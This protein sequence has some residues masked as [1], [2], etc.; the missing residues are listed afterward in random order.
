MTESQLQRAAR[1]TT[2][3]SGWSQEVRWLARELERA[4][5]EADVRGGEWCA[6]NREEGRGPCGACAWCCQQAN[7]MVASLK[8]QVTTVERS[9]VLEQRRTIDAERAQKAAQAHARSA[10]AA[11]SDLKRSLDV[12]REAER[13]VADERESWMADAH[14]AQERAEKAEAEVERLRR[15]ISQ[16]ETDCDRVSQKLNVEK[17]RSANI[18]RRAEQAEAELTKCESMEW[19]INEDAAQ[20]HDRVV[21]AEADVKACQE[22]YAAARAF[23]RTGGGQGCGPEFARLAKAVGL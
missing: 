11:V 3:E 22:V 9:W 8:A 12:A 4:R 6:R 5:A 2:G 1:D 20:L 14:K 23:V 21:R 17:A 15:K 19:K 13:T 18:M 7:L 10:D 16:V